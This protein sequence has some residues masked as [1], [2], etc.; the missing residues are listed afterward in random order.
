MT[1]RVKAT[2][3]AG[4]PLLIMSAIGIALMVQDKP[5]DARATLAVGVIVAATAGASVIY[6]IDRWSLTK[7]TVVHFAIMLATVLPALLLSGW[8]PL[9]SAWGYVAVVG[10]FLAAG[11]VLWAIFYVIFAKLVPRKANAGGAGEAV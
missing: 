4:I 8:F 3:L 10:V 7:Q 6:Q 5:A 2:L 11:F 1:L 9:D